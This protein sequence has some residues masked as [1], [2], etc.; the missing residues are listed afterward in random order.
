MIPGTPNPNPGLYD[1]YVYAI[2]GAPD[3]VLASELLPTPIPEQFPD[4]ITQSKFNGW[5][6]SVHVLYRDTV[7][8]V[9]NP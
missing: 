4:N 6:G 3:S 9:T 8:V 1:I 7:R 2:S 5:V